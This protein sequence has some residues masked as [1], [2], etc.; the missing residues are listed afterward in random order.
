MPF[1]GSKDKPLNRAR[2]YELVDALREPMPKDFSWDFSHVKVY[3]GECGYA[4]CALGLAMLMFPE[5]G[6]RFSEPLANIIEMPDQEINSIF[7]GPYWHRFYNPRASVTPRD[8]AR[9]LGRYL[10][11]TEPDHAI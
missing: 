5:F 4:G 1:D 9:R 10:R 6:R 3:R 11:R 2:L 8:V 7:V